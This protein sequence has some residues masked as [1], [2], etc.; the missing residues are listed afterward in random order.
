ML[1]QENKLDQAVEVLKA[2]LK[3]EPNQ[4][5]ALFMYGMIL[6][7]QGQPQDAIQL[8]EK[9]LKV[10]PKQEAAWSELGLN[11]MKTG[12]LDLAVQS[13]QKSIAIK[14]NYQAYANMGDALYNLNRLDEAASSYNEA[15]KFN[16]ADPL[17][18]RGLGIICYR[19]G[20]SDLAYNL[21]IKSLE[22]FPQQITLNYLL[23]TMLQSSGH[24]WKASEFFKKEIELNP[25]LAEAYIHYG[26][27]LLMTG[28]A[29]DA[30]E[31]YKKG[32]RLKPDKEKYSY[33]LSIM[34]HDY[35]SM[36]A[37]LLE[38]AK[39]CYEVCLLP[40]K[41]HILANNNLSKID[42]SV[43]D[44]NKKLRVGLIS[45]MF[46]VRA[47]DY[48]ALDVF[49]VMNREQFELYFYSDTPVPDEVTAEFKSV[50]DAW[51]EIKTLNNVEVYEL[52]VADKIDILIDLHG[53]V[54]GARLELYALKPAPVEV[55]W[56]NYFGTTGIPEMDYM[57]SDNIVTP[58]GHD[59]FY[60]EKLARLPQ[61]YNPYKPTMA[62]L[63]MAQELP[64]QR[65]GYITF[66]S[67]SRFSK[68]HDQ[69][70]ELW[71]KIM[72]AVPKSRLYVCA[73]SLKEKETVDHVRSYFAAR[74]IAEDR[75]DIVDQPPILEFMMKFNEVDMILDP[76]PFVGATTTMDAMYMGVPTVT[77]TGPTWPYATGA[78]IMITAGCPELIAET[79]D[80]YFQ[81]NVDL[82]ND[83]PRLLK[84]RRGLREQLMSSPICQPEAFANSLETALRAAWQEYCSAIV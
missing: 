17:L 68:L 46:R 2:T 14:K 37:D 75:L 74:G 40:V 39:E 72:N 69:V 12:L 21:F 19:Q 41:Q 15:L 56:L 63:E 29:R 82:A 78:S 76:F 13:F 70:L 49:R 50:A 42:S 22:L 28:R 23:G 71:A 61:F 67:L 73:T 80:E 84:Y 79:K 44:P 83:I 43:K 62:D 59:K 33:L 58:A 8:L 34:S 20:R 48:W 31:I 1:L 53:H 3:S 30:V 47:A 77:L 57:I 4:H 7:H 10:E 32:L 11:Q 60:T 9:S 18:Y 35:A 26:E 45:K 54:G 5:Q 24:H 27:T 51:K 25:N 55:C 65:N 64:V 52:M 38:I 66:G 6:G 81:K 36:P 16:D